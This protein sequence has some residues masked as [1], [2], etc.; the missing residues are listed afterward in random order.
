MR[1]Q[2]VADLLKITSLEDVRR[3]VRAEIQVE[4]KHIERLSPITPGSTVA[5]A[6][7][8]SKAR[9]AAHQQVLAWLADVTEV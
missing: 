8:A 3:L 4:R 7:E 9:I 1:P 6:I 2:L 5:I